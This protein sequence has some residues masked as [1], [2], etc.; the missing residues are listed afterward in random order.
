MA[1]EPAC[2]TSVALPA[3]VGRGR[4]GSKPFNH[5]TNGFVGRG[6]SLVEAQ[7]RGLVLERRVGTVWRGKP[8]SVRS[9]RSEH[10]RQPP[11]GNLVN[12][13]AVSITARNSILRVPGEF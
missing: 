12:A 4:S 3:A 8:V 13:V 11:A 6:G 5:G 2:R 10:S 1:S 7:Q 9:G